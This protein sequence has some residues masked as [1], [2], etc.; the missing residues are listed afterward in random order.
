[1]VFTKSNMNIGKTENTYAGYDKNTV[2][3]FW[4][5]GGVINTLTLSASCE[6]VLEPPRSTSFYCDQYAFGPDCIVIF[7]DG[8]YKVQAR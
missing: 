8:I 4:Y 5:G 2:K 1:M 6:T 3:I 7:E